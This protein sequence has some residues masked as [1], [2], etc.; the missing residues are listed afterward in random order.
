MKI[1]CIATSLTEQK[2][3]ISESNALEQKEWHVE[4]GK[5]YLVFGMSVVDS[6][7][8]NKNCVL[9]EIITSPLGYIS[10]TPLSLFEILDSRVSKY[11]EYRKSNL[12]GITFWPSL[13]YQDFFHDDL[14]DGEP[15]VV[16]QF[17]KLKTLLEAE[18]P[19]PSIPIACILEKNWHQC[20]ICSDAWQP[21]KM[22]ENCPSCGTLCKMA[23]QN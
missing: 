9:V 10:S 23:E 5:E 22:I 21:S 15:D 7:L 3:D 13:F 17:R 6:F 2:Q 11:W 16:A 18:Y 12:E 20:P 4:L 19:D 8:G 1:K 14:S